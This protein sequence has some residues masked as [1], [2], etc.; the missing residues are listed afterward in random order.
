MGMPEELAVTAEMTRTKL[1]RESAWLLIS[2]QSS[3][4]I[5]YA[6]RHSQSTVR[7]DMFN[8][9]NGVLW[10]RGCHVGWRLK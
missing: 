6:K 3:T 4:Y 10:I 2:R 8:N 5:A 7:L 9:G 1:I